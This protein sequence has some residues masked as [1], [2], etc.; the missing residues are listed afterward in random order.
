MLLL[1]HPA[2]R[3]GKEARRRKKETQAPAAGLSLFLLPLYTQDS[4]ASIFNTTQ[5]ISSEHCSQ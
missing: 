4:T 1:D 3:V 2:G 5:L